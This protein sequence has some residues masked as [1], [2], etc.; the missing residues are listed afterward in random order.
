MKKNVVFFAAALVVA[1]VVAG[2]LWLQLDESRTQNADLQARLRTSEGAELAPVN[3]PVS[4]EQTAVDDALSQAGV[5]AGT[6]AVQSDARPAATDSPGVGLLD[7]ARQIMSNPAGRELVQP[8]LR[9]M[10]QQRFK[11]VGEALQLSREEEDTLFD[12][13]ARQ[14]MDLSAASMELLTGEN[15]DA[16]SRRELELRV[17]EMQRAS[18]AE[19]A[20]MLGSKF[21]QLQ[22]FE[23]TMAAR[24]QVDQLRALLD[25]S[26]EVLTDTQGR[27][28]VSALAAEQKRITEQLNANPVPAGR[29]RQEA[30]QVQVARMVES[31]QRLIEIASRHLNARQLDSYRNMLDQQTELLKRLMG[32]ADGAGA[33]SARSAVTTP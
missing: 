11:G 23:S 27:S 33:V 3:A 30:L 2:Y 10:I 16:G 32:V 12:T 8:A 14:Q 17:Q 18:E 9:G 5:P 15:T 19:L 6:D 28:L 4:K 7:G 31:N 26:G 29:S 21:P 1:G 24:Q 13:L 25:S 22:E 20:S